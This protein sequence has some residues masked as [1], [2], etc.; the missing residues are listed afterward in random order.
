MAQSLNPEGY[1]FL[2]ASETITGYSD[3]FEM[4]RSPHGVYYRLKS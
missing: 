4:I 3:A 1:L 2:G